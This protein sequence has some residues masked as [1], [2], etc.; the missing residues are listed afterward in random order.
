MKLQGQVAIVVGGA[1]GI[2]EAIAHAF[3]QEGASVAI[4]A[5]R[6]DLLRAPA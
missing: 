2:G 3:A 6:A 5:R 4:C 1:R